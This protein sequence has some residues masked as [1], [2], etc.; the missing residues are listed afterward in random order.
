MLKFQ[1]KKTIVKRDSLEQND[2]KTAI[3]CFCFEWG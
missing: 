2:I 3:F 1:E